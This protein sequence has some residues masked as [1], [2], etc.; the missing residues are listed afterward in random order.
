MS[1]ENTNS[2]NAAETR[3]IELIDSAIST[4]VESDKVA[5]LNQAQEFVI[6]HDIL[7]NFLDEI[8]G[9]QS[10]RYSDVRK[11]VAGFIEATCKKEPDYFPKVIVNLN[12]MLTDEVPNVLKKSIQ[13]CTQLYKVFLQWIYQSKLTDEIES[14]WDVWSQIKTYIFMLIDSTE[15]DGIRTQCIKFIENVIL[16]Q[17]KRDPFTTDEFSLDQLIGIEH[18]LIDP[19]SLEEEAIQLFDQLVAFQA[20]IHISSVN[21]MAT[22]QTLSLVARQRSKLFYVKVVDAFEALST[23]LPPTLAKSQVNSVNKQLKLLFI[24]LLKHPFLNSTKLQ[25]KISDL[26]LN[27]GASNQ[28]INR[29]LQ[30]FRKRSFKPDSNNVSSIESK[31]I[32]LEPVDDDDVNYNKDQIEQQT[33]INMDNCLYELSKKFSRQDASKATEVTS[34]DLL[35]R[36]SNINLVSDIV[37]SSLYLLPDKINDKLRSILLESANTDQ[38]NEVSKQLAFQ[39]TSLGIGPG[40]DEMIAKYSTLFANSNKITKIDSETNK[41][42]TNIVKKCISKELKKQDVHHHSTKV[43]L[44]QSGKSMAS[45]VKIKQFNLMDVTKPLDAQ[46]KLKYIENSIRRILSDDKNGHFSSKEFETQH[47]IIGKFLSDFSNFESLKSIIKEYI[48]NDIRNRYDILMNMIYKEY[49]NG[50]DT[51]SHEYYGTCLAWVIQNIINIPELKDRDTFLSKFYLES[52]YLPDNV[53][54]MLKTFIL[55]NSSINLKCSISG[56]SLTKLLIEKRQRYRK[57]L[58]NNL[59]QISVITSSQDLTKLSLDTVKQLYENNELLLV[60]QIEEFAINNLRKLLEET[61]DPELFDSK[62]LSWNDDTIMRCLS[63]YLLLLPMNN[64]L[65][66]QLPNVYVGSH[67]NI[68]RVINRAIQNS[69]EAIDINSKEI[70]TFVETCPV[71]ADPLISRVIR[72]LADKQTPS[73]ELVARVK[74]LYHKS[75]SDVRFLFPVLN[76]FSKREIIALLPQ[77]IKQNPNTVKEIFNRLLVPSQDSNSP[78][79]PADLLIALHNV[80]ETKCDLKT[81]IKATNLCFEEKNIFTA[82]VLAI[83]MQMLIEQNPLPTLL[84]RTVI[85]TLSSYPRLITFIMNNILQKLIVKQ[86]WTQKK[87]WEGFVKCCQRTMPHSFGVMLQL[88]PIQLKSIISVC[89]EIKPALAEHLQTLS[90]QQLIHLPQMVKDIIFE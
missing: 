16:C 58:L 64:K 17:T 36:L 42:I 35:T 39:F 29:C 50:K 75:V 37:L 2:S 26:L 12:M 20:K 22:M 78:I 59:L 53:L 83:V 80:D 7:D 82:E 45:N 24:N 52:P 41:K 9:F 73:A 15:N 77:L 11:F 4:N 49:I 69:I 90:E 44:T 88:H 57:F 27:L 34:K 40:I 74:D 55:N 60:G 28:E 86:V 71:G 43:K 18:K 56:I 31:R 14:T 6:H 19:E 38:T 66:H 84:M 33:N 47:K 10:D 1:E 70:L 79:S 89:P 76:G 72:I 8:L 30:D 54:L 62:D 46:S 23:N 85:Q 61:P 48:F 63:L 51:T 68:Q 25:P 65:L 21:L 5:F 87:V 3:V 67:R 13:V 32:K 81:I